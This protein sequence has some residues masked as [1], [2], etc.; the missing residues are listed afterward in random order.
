[1]VLDARAFESFWR[2]EAA[3]ENPLT[4]MVVRSKSC[5][6]AAACAPV[7]LSSLPLLSLG[8]SSR[9]IIFS[10]YSRCFFSASLSASSDTA[11]APSAAARALRRRAVTSE[12]DW[13]SVISSA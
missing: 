12:R 5:T 6:E 11:P 13:N 7:L 3:R 2:E 10:E 8:P 1:M 9:S 4:S